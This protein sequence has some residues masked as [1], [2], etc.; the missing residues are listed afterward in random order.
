MGQRLALW[1]SNLRTK[2]S[3]QM[4]QAAYFYGGDYQRVL[5]ALGWRQMWSPSYAHA[6][7]G[8][9]ERLNRTLL[10]MV[11]PVLYSA[12]LSAAFWTEAAAYAAW[13]LFRTVPSRSSS[14]SVSP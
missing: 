5:I 10:D 9:S 7:N 6:L 3:I 2:P 11:R 8:A 4:D 1:H 12:H 14:A 13:T